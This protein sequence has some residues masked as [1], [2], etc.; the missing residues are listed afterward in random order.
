MFP[1]LRNEVTKDPL[2]SGSMGSFGEFILR[3]RRAQEWE[4]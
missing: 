2:H 1:F 3:N 4:G